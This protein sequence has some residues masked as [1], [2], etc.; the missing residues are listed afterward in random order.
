MEG[1]N[2]G[3]LSRGEGTI[4]LRGLSKGLR[5][6]RGIGEL[7]SAGAGRGGRGNCQSPEPMGIRTEKECSFAHVHILEGR[8]RGR[9]EV[10]W[11]RK[12]ELQG[13]KKASIFHGMSFKDLEGREGLLVER[14][15]IR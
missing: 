10:C 12:G 11:G 6:K 5:E 15:G 8:R 13:K 9:G 3:S 1:Q 7:P 14:S 4:R 2:Q